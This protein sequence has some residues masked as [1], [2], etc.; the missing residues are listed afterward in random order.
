M[1]R[2]WMKSWQKDLPTTLTFAYGKNHCMST[3]GCAR[4]KC[5]IKVP[6][7]SMAER[8]GYRELDEASDRFANYLRQNGVKKGDR[9]AIFMGNCPSTKLP[10]LVYRNW[11]LLSVPAHRSSRKWS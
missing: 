9:V 3:Y 6:L 8:S 11:A 7:S 1:E 5:L 2:I 10:I 4:Q